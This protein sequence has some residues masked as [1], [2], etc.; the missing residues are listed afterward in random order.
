MT[1]WIY[2]CVKQGTYDGCGRKLELAAEL[3][4][5]LTTCFHCNTLNKCIAKEPPTTNTYTPIT[6]WSS[7]AGVGQTPDT[8]SELNRTVTS[9]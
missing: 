8:G 7:G 3:V 1:Y 2:N 6:A 9:T 4:L 5:C